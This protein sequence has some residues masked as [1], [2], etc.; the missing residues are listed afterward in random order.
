VVET[1][2]ILG[3]EWNDFVC[4]WKRVDIEN[5][6]KNIT[7][8]KEIINNIGILEKKI[9]NYGLVTRKKC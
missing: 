4:V 9:N 8:H 5:I 6:E 3:Q 2:N 1:F 7:V